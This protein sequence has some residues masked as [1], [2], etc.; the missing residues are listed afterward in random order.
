MLTP[1]AWLTVQRSETGEDPDT[2]IVIVEIRGWNH[3]AT[4][5]FK[6]HEV[7]ALFDDLKRALEDS[8][9][10]MRHED[11]GLTDPDDIPF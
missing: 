1:S 7:Q 8:V 2:E 4:F 11:L 6:V 10:M 3:G 9:P 5:E